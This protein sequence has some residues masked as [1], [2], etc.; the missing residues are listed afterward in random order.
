MCLAAIASDE[1]RAAIDAGGPEVI[2]RRALIDLAGA[3]LGRTFR[4]RRIPPWLARPAWAGARLGHPP[5]GHLSSF[6]AAL[7]P[8]ARTSVLL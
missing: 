6:V 5:M 7:A 1:P 3:A 4:V 8:P 2:T